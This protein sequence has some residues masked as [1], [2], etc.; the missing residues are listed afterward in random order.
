MRGSQLS[1]CQ[2]NPQMLGRGWSRKDTVGVWLA[3]NVGGWCLPSP[4]CA[5]RAWSPLLLGSDSVSRAC[6]AT[7]RAF[8]IIMKSGEDRIH[9]AHLRVTCGCVCARAHVFDTVFV[10]ML[11]LTAPGTLGLL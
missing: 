5:V 7:R 9:W 2:L 6:P 10:L 4:A 8:E 3:V 1:N 11:H